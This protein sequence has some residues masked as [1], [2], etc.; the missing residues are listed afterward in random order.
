MR[1]PTPFSRKTSDDDG[2]ALRT[3]AICEVQLLEIKEVEPKQ[4]GKG[5]GGDEAQSDKEGND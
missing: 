4:E 1:K 2:K 5:N 3:K